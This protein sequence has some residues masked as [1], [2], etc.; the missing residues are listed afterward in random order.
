[1]RTRVRGW[2]RRHNPLRR[3]S[4]VVEAWA[5]LAAAVLLCVGA[6][7]TG[8]LVGHWA[9]DDV[10]ALAT[11]QRAE[12]HRVR[13]VVVADATDPLSAVQGRRDRVY[14]ATVRWTEPGTGVRS[15][16]V[17]VP[18]GARVGDTV[19]VW[20][21]TRGRDVGP[22]TDDVVVWQHTITLAVCAA[23]AFAGLVLLGHGLLRRAAW[24]RRL[25]DWDR[26]WARTGPDWTRK[27]A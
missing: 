10:R 2:R 7:L 5:V 27:R 21:D 14:R 15:A 17:R 8:V 18:V 24:N 4:D 12:R 16:E 6:P 22:P 1:M 3:R 23:G 19:E 26:E 20:F 11:A 13:A 9:Y 25:A